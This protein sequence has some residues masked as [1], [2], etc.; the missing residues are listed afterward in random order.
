MATLQIRYGS[1]SVPDLK[2]GEL[3]NNQTTRSLQMGIVDS[4][5]ITLAKL[6]ETNIG[7]FEVSGDISASG[8]LFISGNA[9]IVGNLTFGDSNAID[10][11]TVVASLS[12]SLIPQSNNSFDLG[13]TTTYWK[14]AY[15]SAITGSLSG[16][17]NGTNITTFSASVSSSIG[18]LNNSSY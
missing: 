14:T 13:N 7:N 16:S 3:Y 6:N 5:L 1:S 17:V 4:D 15:I 2:A 8:N 11:V 10:T 12:S 18:N 9:R